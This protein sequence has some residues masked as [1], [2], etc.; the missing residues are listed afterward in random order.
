MMTPAAEPL[1]AQTRQHL[2]AVRDALL[3]LHKAL[4]DD[5]RAAYERIHGR[6][7][8]ARLLELLLTDP[9]FAWLRTVSGMVVRMDESL[10]PRSAATEQEG[11]QLVRLVRETIM[12]D[13]NGFGFGVKYHVA[14][15]RE[16]AVLL[17]HCTL[18]KLL[19]AP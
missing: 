14:V 4:L 12:P 1:S 18:R 10:A 6:V 5:E 15:Q 8:P 9:W 13:E 19:P 11:L 17:A 3:R 16:P 2:R 7:T